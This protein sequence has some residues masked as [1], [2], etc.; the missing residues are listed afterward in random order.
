[1]PFSC[2]PKNASP[3]VQNVQQLPPQSKGPG[4]SQM[5][6]HKHANVSIPRIV[7]DGT[8]FDRETYSWDK[9]GLD[10]NLTTVTFADSLY[11]TQSEINLS[12]SS[13]SFS[14]SPT[15]LSLPKKHRKVPALSS[16]DLAT[17]FNVPEY[18]IKK[19]DQTRRFS[20]TT[21]HHQTVRESA[22]EET[23]KETFFSIASSQVGS[24]HLQ[25]EDNAAEMS[26][27]IG[28]SHD[29]QSMLGGDTGSM[30]PSTAGNFNLSLV[31]LN[32]QYMLSLLGQLGPPRRRSVIQGERKRGAVG[33]M[34][35]A[36]E[37]YDRESVVDMFPSIRSLGNKV[38]RTGGGTKTKG[39]T[40][41][42]P[43]DH[44]NNSIASELVTSLLIYTI[45]CSSRIINVPCRRVDDTF[46][47][48]DSFS[49]ASL[50][51]FILFMSSYMH[52][53]VYI[54]SASCLYLLRVL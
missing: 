2:E 18:V 26:N 17:F 50:I 42:H 40:N 33:V 11:T 51:C 12:S 54:P 28:I 8:V 38:R 48:I 31:D 25:G 13:S 46:I 16:I 4:G 10:P 45:F 32:L 7:F 36:G 9:R 6:T 34:E 35:D 22:E 44:S 5:M 30:L 52:T 24:E 15:H 49:I 41:T 39:V 3:F 53:L 19:H 1:M 37:N 20:M 23:S 14:S 29:L 47:C 21:N 43:G 27:W